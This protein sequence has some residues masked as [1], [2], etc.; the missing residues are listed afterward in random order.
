MMSIVACYEWQAA[1]DAAA[2][3][4]FAPD[5]RDLWPAPRVELEVFA[6]DGRDLTGGPYAPHP[7]LGLLSP[8]GREIWDSHRECHG[9]FELEGRRWPC[10]WVYG[11]EE[12]RWSQSGLWYFDDAKV[13]GPK[14]RD[15][16]HEARVA[17]REA[18]W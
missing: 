10:V 3:R 18:S 2:A 16:E 11:P 12:Y 15:R 9:R 6:P 4:L 14:G 5:G 7:I 8:E 17:K 13:F 1:R